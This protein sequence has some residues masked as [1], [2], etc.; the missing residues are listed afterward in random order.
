MTDRAYKMFVP[1]RPEA[2]VVG[3]KY[4]IGTTTGIYMKA[5]DAPDGVTYYKFF[6][7]QNPNLQRFRF[8]TYSTPF[9]QFVSDNPQG[10]MEQRS[11]NIVVRR[12]IGDACFKW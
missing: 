7:Q 10:K 5:W 3:A 4:K 9:Q 12:L 2:L 11:V 6:D 8:F 1:I